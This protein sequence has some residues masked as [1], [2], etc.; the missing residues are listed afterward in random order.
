MKAVAGGIGAELHLEL[1]AM[2]ITVTVS[3][4]RLILIDREHKLSG[5]RFA[6]YELLNALDRLVE[7]AHDF[8][9][10]LPKG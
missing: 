7:H 9:A 8:I 3:D 10:T 4:E 5:E 2:G 6:R 1:P